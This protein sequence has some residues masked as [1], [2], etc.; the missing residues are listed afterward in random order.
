MKP[1]E[2]GATNWL[3]LQRICRIRTGQMNGSSSISSGTNDELSSSMATPV[4]LCLQ[5]GIR[6]LSNERNFALNVS[7]AFYKSR[8]YVLGARPNF[9]RN[10]VAR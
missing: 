2:S 8:L 1:S 5:K 9:D 4:Q 6:F 3:A 10:A 7:T